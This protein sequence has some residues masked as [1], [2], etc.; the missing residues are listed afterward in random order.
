MRVLFSADFHGD[1]SRLFQLA[2]QADLCICCGDIFDYHQLPSGDFEFPLPF[3]TVKGNKELW[4]QKK[5]QQALERCHNFFWL[6]HHLDKLEELT[7]MRFAGIDHRK[8]PTTI[9][10]SID[11]LVSHQPAH[12]LADQ[13][14][15]PFHA[16]MIP[17]CGS[18]AVKRLVDLSQPRL[19]VAGH[20]HQF[21]QQQIGNIRA[22]TLSP[23]LSNPVLML[24]GEHLELIDY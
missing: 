16:K 11:V 6:N 1:F 10:E 14:G 5:L 21:Q 17:H 4:G 22:V 15:D 7:G 13:C 12:G 24:R 8:E 20:V 2:G 3:F 19:V 23:A 18:K 9:P